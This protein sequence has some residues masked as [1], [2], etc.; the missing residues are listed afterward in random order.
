MVYLVSSMTLYFVLAI[1]IHRCLLEFTRDQV[2]NAHRI[3]NPGCYATG[4]QMALYP[5]VAQ[6]DAHCS[7]TVFGVS[8]Y[9][10]AGTKPSPKNDP[11]YLKDNLIP[12]SL[13]NHIH[14]REVSHR[15]G[16][17]IAFVPHVASWFQGI[18]LTVSI[19]LAKSMTSQEI[20]EL[21]E[22]QYTGEK[23]VRIEK[24]GI[25][26]VRDISGKHGV[27][28]G[29]FQVDTTG[30]RAVIISNI[31]NL[32]KGAATQA[33]QVSVTMPRLGMQAIC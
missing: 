2:K 11:T 33:I 32:L 23:L 18:S 7:P 10:G 8:G 5:L 12:Y 17:P 4:A 26:V 6:M 14:E 24:T 20:L 31:D 19:P 29:G 15:L 21:F 22:E 27:T 16:R 9:S 28:L 25:P 30:R 3:S 1:I 13:T